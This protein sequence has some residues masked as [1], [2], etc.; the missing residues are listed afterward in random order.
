M[1]LESLRS[2]WNREPR[3]TRRAARGSSEEGCWTSLMRFRQEIVKLDPSSPHHDDEL[4]ELEAMRVV[5]EA[6]IAYA[7]RYANALQRLAS[8]EEERDNNNNTSRKK[9]LEQMA[10]ICSWVPAHAP[11]TFWEALQH[12]WFVHVGITYELNPWDSFTRA[13]LINTC[14]H[15]TKQ[16]S[17]ATSSHGKWPRNSWNRSG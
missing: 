11:R 3:A 6:M 9:E 12:Y 7:S 1:R 14:T 13:A 2:S 15:F 10:E 5:S 17:S 16:I 8:E 4:Q